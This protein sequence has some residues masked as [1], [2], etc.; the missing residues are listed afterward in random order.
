MTSGEKKRKFLFME[1]ASNLQAYAHANRRVLLGEVDGKKTI[2][3]GPVYCCPLCTLFYIG[4]INIMGPKPHLSLEDNPPVSL[5][6]KPLILT[7]SSCNSTYGSTTD[8]VIGKYL[9]DGDFLEEGKVNSTLSV[10]AVVDN[11][12]MPSKL[13]IRDDGF[14]AI[15]IDERINEH[16]A[17]KF[18]Q[19]FEEK[20]GE[21]IRLHFWTTKSEKVNGA[22]L[23]ILHLE[24]FRHFGYSYLFNQNGEF[25]LNSLK[26]SIEHIPN[27]GRLAVLPETV[28][29]GLHCAWVEDV[30]F[31]LIVF[32]IK[33]LKKTYKIGMPLPGP[34]EIG[35][36]QYLNLNN[37]LGLE[38]QARFMKDYALPYNSPHP[39]RYQ[40]LWQS[41]L[42]AVPL[43]CS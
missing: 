14:I 9:D 19:A 27:H 15:H 42:E 16:V 41:F 33:T 3:T 13:E 11:A 4:P 17:K 5:G 30:R 29:D 39:N 24:A 40:A 35:R 43:P 10:R 25:I 8:H 26:S 18:V 37:K 2:H 23:K 28:M 31:Y 7:C 12:H 38:I 21:A 36:Q 32:S 20:N 22:F 34:D 6:G 1:Y